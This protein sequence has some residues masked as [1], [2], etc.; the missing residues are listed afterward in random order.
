M[1]LVFSILT[2]TY[3]FEYGRKI[4]VLGYVNPSSGIV[5]VYSPNDGY[6]RN[7]F[8]TEGQEVYNGLPL[9]KVEYRKHFEKITDNKNKDRYIC[10]AAIPNHWVINPGSI[11]SMC[12]VALDSKANHVG[13]IS[14]DGKLNLNIKLAN[15]W[16][17]SLINLD[18]ESMRR[19]LHDLKNKYNTISVVNV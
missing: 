3:F 14:G 1:F 6:I 19:P 12:T 9:A 16:H 7:K 13:H 8:I 18:W 4:K 10:Y 15:E 17:N 2:F 5:K 11:V